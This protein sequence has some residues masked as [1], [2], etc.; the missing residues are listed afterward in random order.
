MRADDRDH[1][2][3]D[4]AGRSS[5]SVLSLKELTDR[6]HSYHGHRWRDSGSEGKSL[7]TGKL[8]VYPLDLCVTGK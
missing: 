6:G 4:K 3:G 5:A 2:G 8:G 7:P 1:L